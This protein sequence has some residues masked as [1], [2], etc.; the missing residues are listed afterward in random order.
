MAQLNEEQIK[1]VQHFNG[2][3]LVSACPG[4]GKTRVITF[5]AIHLIR[6]GISPHR[7]L[8]VTFTNKA[9]RE[10]RDRIEKL[11]H[12]NSVSSFGMI[13]STFHSMCLEIMRKSSTISKDY[14]RANILDTDDVESLI[15]SIN[16]EHDMSLDKDEIQGFIHGY[17]SLREKAL[18]KDSIR[19]E[20]VKFNGVYGNLMDCFDQSMNHMNALDFSAI[21]YNFWQELL[22]N[23]NFRKEVQEMYDFVMIDEVQ[24]TNIIQFEIAK[25]ICEKH[26]NVFMVGD[27]DQSIYQWRGANPG[28]VSQFVRSTNCTIYRLT[29]NYRCTG[30]ITKI[31]SSL[32]NH[33]SNRLN[34][35][36]LS[37]RDS[38]EPVRLSVACT[39]DEESENIAKNIIKIKASGINMK[40]VAIL[41]R[42]S[43]LTRS[44][45][46]AMM[47]H[48]IP[49]SIT[50]GFRFYDREEIKDIISMLRFVY[51][52]RDVISFSRFMNKP[53]RGLGSKCV[54]AIS[55]S[56][57]R[58]GLT[59]GLQ[60]YLSQSTDMKEAN[61]NA[62]FRLIEN[63][64][65]KPVK[66]MPL[67]ELTEHLVEE[68]KY[69]DYLKTFK[70]DVPQDKMDNILELI[71]SMGISNQS[72]GEFLTSVSLMS[73]PKEAT[74][75]DVINSVKIMTMHASKGLEF[76][77]VFLPCMEEETLPHRRSL[78]EGPKGLEEERRLAYVAI[79]R[80]MDRL[81]ISTALFDGGR[82]R[83]MKMPS[84]F[85]FESGL[86]D[87]DI[88]Y[89][90]AQ[91]ARNS[92][93]A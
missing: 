54:Q 17:S 48:N 83:S 2:P 18:S 35:E 79:T 56:S 43:H 80:A 4:A 74:E 64:F 20:I 57:L 77:N 68:T 47:R 11:A 72:I 65:S 15:K 50:G 28:Q 14:K 78:A 91:E 45:E 34:S 60:Q 67:K 52:P 53:R 93:M 7:I 89:E 51:N 38:G 39:R 5:R 49:Y 82:E 71:K 66:D 90:L 25:I 85:L 36:I 41:V 40:D 62:I 10:M 31:A 8:L 23:E 42:A 63:I 55:A 59:N 86:C 27:T 46:Q 84:R 30:S 19:E 58:G 6:K 32:I 44:I 3:C 12:D 33:N 92:Y 61:K 69:K 16:E 88:Y 76:D 26:N 75:E 87:K 73:T 21:M 24:D 1:A 13:V 81:W 9:A 22:N 37:H 29:K 70:G